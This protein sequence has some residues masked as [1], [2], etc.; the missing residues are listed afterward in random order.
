ADDIYRRLYS[1]QVA[2]GF[3][4]FIPEIVNAAP[5][6]STLANNEKNADDKR[7]NLLARLRHPI[8]QQAGLG[9][10]LLAF[11]SAITGEN[12]AVLLGNPHWYWG[13][14]DRFYQ[15]HLT[16][17]GRLDAAGVAF[18]GVPVI[19]VGFNNQVAWTH[20]V[21]IARRFGL[22]DLT[23]D[24]NDPTRYQI[25]GAVEKMSARTISVDVRNEDGRIQKI[26]RRFYRSRLG[27][28]VDLGAHDPALGWSNGHAL[29]LRDANEDNYRVFR[30]YFYWNQATSLDDFIAIQKREVAV[31]WANT[32]AIGRNNG[33]VWYSD[34][35]PAPNVSDLQRQQCATDRTRGYAQIDPQTPFLDGSRTTCHWQNDSAAIQPGVLTAAK[36]PSLL[37]E[38][39]VAN[40]NDSYW[41]TNAKQPL[42]GFSWLL[43]GERQELSWRGLMGQQLA[44]EL[45][46][47]APQSQTAL[48]QRLMQAALT[49]RAY[50][51]EQFKSSLLQQ[52]CAQPDVVLK[53]ENP[54]STPRVIRVSAACN[55]LQ[56]WNSRSEADAKGALLWD[57]FW[58]ELETIPASDLFQVPFSADTP[59]TT[60][61]DPALNDGRIAQALARA[62]ATFEDRGVDPAATVGSQRFVRSD[63][64]NIPFFGA[65]QNV[66]YFAIACNPVGYGGGASGDEVLGPDTIANSYL[67]VVHFDDAGVNAHTLLA[68]GLEETAVTNGPGSAPVQRYANKR[69]LPFPFQ[70]QQIDQDPALRR[71]TLVF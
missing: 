8:G 37:R 64:R 9:S 52:A 49:P 53:Q 40:M 36:L 61:R 18:L 16:I 51:A 24:A 38:D 10:N 65:C 70:Q 5:N 15:M 44:Q 62:L 42:E 21:S 30:N 27:P 20:T 68:H 25:D 26:S 28:V 34:M 17:P 48:S 22:F 66:G 58:T 39:Y 2:G 57:A 50:T 47:P 55:V 7:Q 35:G 45:M 69:W 63:Q 41:L 4:H 33:R 31:P 32:A 1:A 14:P 43:G 71:W 6:K 19:M 67:Q 60:P 54:A 29:V 12:A 3:G 23:L 13:G 46:V 56:Q 11:G 59:L